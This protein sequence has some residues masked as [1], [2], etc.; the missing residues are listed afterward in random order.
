[1][2]STLLA[3]VQNI[4]AKVYKTSTSLSIEVIH[5]ITWKDL[6]IDLSKSEVMKLSISEFILYFKI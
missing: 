4:I 1:M 2:D 3:N 6:K 5:I